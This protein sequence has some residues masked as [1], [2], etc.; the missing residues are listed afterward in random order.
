M[1]TYR[2]S[3]PVK[4]LEISKLEDLRFLVSDSWGKVELDIFQSQE[5][6]VYVL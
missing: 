6:L 5:T 2:H 3:P 4:F 1:N